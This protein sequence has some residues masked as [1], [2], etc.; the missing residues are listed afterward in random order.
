MDL[1]TYRPGLGILGTGLILWITG[2]LFMTLLPAVAAV[3]AVL[4]LVGQI[5]FWLGV[6]VLLIQV[7]ISLIKG[8]L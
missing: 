4:V 8:A 7:I 6:A 5:L 1:V 3:G 2:I